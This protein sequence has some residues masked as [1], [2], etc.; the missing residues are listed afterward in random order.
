MTLRIRSSYV[1]RMRE[2]HGNAT[3][4][5]DA[6]PASVFDFVTDIS[7]LPEWSA[8]VTRVIE[9]PAPLSYR[10]EW[11]AARAPAWTTAAGQGVPASLDAIRQHLS[12]RSVI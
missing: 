9:A 4:F 7:R 6:T 2:F 3:Q 11:V 5:V 10:A 12:R 8:A 1:H